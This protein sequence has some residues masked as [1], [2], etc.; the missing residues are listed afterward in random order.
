MSI[1]REQLQRIRRH[2]D[3]DKISAM[4][5]WILDKNALDLALERE[6]L[7][8]TKVAA[9]EAQLAAVSLSLHQA[10]EIK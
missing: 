4:G 1:T 10:T 6:E 3:G 5:A 9:L 8:K 7:L 2:L